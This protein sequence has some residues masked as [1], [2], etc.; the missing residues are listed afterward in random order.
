MKVLVLVSRFDRGGAETLECELAIHLNKIGIESHLA[1]QF[2]ENHFEGN[3][4]AI[5]H[6]ERGLENRIFWLHFNKG[7]WFGVINLIKLIKK[8]K[9]DV[10]IA[11][12]ANLNIVVGISSLFSKFKHICAFH[13]YLSKKSYSFLHFHIWRFFV[14]RAAHS[15]AISNFT[16]ENIIDTFNLDNNKITTI[17]NSIT[18]KDEIALKVSIR[19]KLGLNPEIKI[20]VCAGRMNFLKGFD[21]DIMIF[22]RL[23]TPAALIF[24]GDYTTSEEEEYLKQLQLL[25]QESP[26][27]EQIFFLGFRQDIYSIFN[28]SDLFLHLTRKEGFGLVLLEAIYTKLPVVSSNV[29][30][31]PEVLKTSPYETF[32]IAD[33]KK[34]I[35]KIDFYLNMSVEEKSKMVASAFK[36]LDYFTHE[37]RAKNIKELMESL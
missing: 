2:D 1:G 3:R 37:R 30:G 31:I 29:G 11:H 33:E 8:E 26:R 27:K 14:K 5:K 35:E 10:I 20:I 16:R 23:K 9:Y 15:Y 4:F 22:N 34:I 19:E 6:R 17:Y 18:F 21:L 24:V 32:D 36:S 7:I 12:N 13:E 28:E 25:A